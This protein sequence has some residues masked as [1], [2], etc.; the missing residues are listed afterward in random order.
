MTSTYLQIDIRDRHDPTFQRMAEHILRAQRYCWFSEGFVKASDGETIN[1]DDESMSYETVFHTESIGRTCMNARYT[2]LLESLNTNSSSPSGDCT[3]CV[4]NIDLDNHSYSLRIPLLGFL[5]FAIVC[6]FAKEA[7]KITDFESR[8]RLFQTVDS[9]M[10]N[11]TVPI[12][13]QKQ[14]VKHIIDGVGLFDA[15]IVD[16]MNV[17]LGNPIIQIG[18]VQTRTVSKKT[19][20]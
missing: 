11:G 3:V 5:A 8:M 19:E 6:E 14:I 12:K 18:D 10:L 4:T 2:H 20:T 7:D 13:I 17:D 1:S 15:T 9:Q 16:S